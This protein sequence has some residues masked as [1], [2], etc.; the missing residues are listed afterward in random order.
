MPACGHCLQCPSGVYPQLV[1]P[2]STP[3]KDILVI[4]ETLTAI[5]AR[6][7][8]CM[9][10]AGAEIL[11]QTMDKVGLPFT[12][13][14]VHYTV[15]VTCAIPKKKGKQFPKE[16]QMHC[17]NR[18]IEEIKAVQPKIVIVLGK[19]AYQ[20]L[21][22]DFNVKITEAYGRPF[23][24]DFLPKTMTV[25][26][27]M[28]PGLIMRSPGDYK[29]FLASMFLVAN[30][31]KGNQAYDTGETRWQVLKTEEDCDRAIELLKRYPRYAA[32]M[33]T[34]GLDYREVEFLVMGICFAK[35]RVLIIPR[36]LRHRVQDFYDALHGK[37]TWHH[38][39]YDTKV[40]WRRKVAKALP[41]DND[42]IYM[43]YVLDETSAHDLGT[44]TKNFLQAA[45][46]KYKMNQ[47][48]KSV[49]LESYPKFFDALCERVAVDC[50]YSFQLEDVL[51]AELDKPE[52]A[53]LKKN[54]ETLI[55]PAARFLTRVE[56]N[57]MLVDE[58]YLQEL[59][60]KYEAWLKQILIEVEDAAAPYWNRE[61]YMQETEAKSAPIKFNPGSPKQ[62]AWMIFDRLKLKPRLKKGRST[63]KDI[64]KSI[65]TDL[66][67]VKKVLEYRRVQKEKSTYVVGT[68]NQRDVDGRVRSTFSLH[69][70][71]TGR[72]TS[73]EPNVQNVPSANGVGNI[74]RAYVPRE[75]FVLLEQDYSGA[76]LR[77]LAFLSRCPVLM[78]V[79]RD[80]RNLHHETATSVFGEHYTK[81]QKMRAKAL[82][83]G[84]PYG[85][86]DQSFVDEFN[87]SHDEAHTM[88]MGWLN[89]YYGARDY[90]DWCADQVIAGNYLETPWG[91]RRRFGLVTPESLHALQNEARNFPIQSS[92]S[93]LLLY[94]AMQVEDRLRNEYNTTIIDLVHDS[95]LLEVPKDL[96][97]VKGVSEYVNS[98]MI[99]APIDL[100]NCDV[101]FKTDCDVGP[102]W[103]HVTPFNAKTGNMEIEQSDG[104]DLIIPYVEWIQEN[105]HWELYQRQWYKQLQTV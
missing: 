14:K 24:P 1:R 45:E 30:L 48:W 55:M 37:W 49:S 27:V 66:P 35:N 50:D 85:R 71:A 73:K 86:E 15:A 80:G 56:K 3:H 105:Y 75:G 39:K 90:L 89:T 4:G 17:R 40:Q 20:T 65:D 57:G 21:M 102:D 63:D 18:L 87:I 28:H 64:L 93:D 95:M 52:N 26:P 62:M 98:V 69:I 25:I 7:G 31:Y 22:G 16:P 94:S 8:I 78:G 91:R 32:D 38:G 61:L 33:E 12:E 68:L 42:T 81:Q 84:I 6:R 82:N 67:L 13:D 60:V 74:R 101:P 44:L 11:K 96:A 104:P 103:Y 2:W 19:V 59:D 79:F 83:F 10:G 77:W 100:F 99:Q 47:N 70:A 88:R 53:C 58:E 43:H 34:T 36:E 97:Y 5:E 46:Y 92:S 23:T 29:P 76:E 54:Y 51:Q 72:L 9:S 41:L